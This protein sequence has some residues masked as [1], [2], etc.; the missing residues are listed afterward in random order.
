MHDDTAP[1]GCIEAL[2]ANPA[3]TTPPAQLK[4]QVLSYQTKLN[5]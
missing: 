2:H 1:Q 5:R 3:L 4:M